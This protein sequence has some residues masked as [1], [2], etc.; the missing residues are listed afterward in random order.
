MSISEFAVSMFGLSQRRITDICG[1][2][3]KC[4]YA[5]CTYSHERQALLMYN[6]I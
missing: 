6:I 4:T 1:Y 2:S 5:L 3:V